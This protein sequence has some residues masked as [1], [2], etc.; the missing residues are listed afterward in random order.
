MIDIII[1]NPIDFYKVD[2]GY[3]FFFSLILDIKISLMHLDV[4]EREERGLVE[5]VDLDPTLPLGSVELPPPLDTSDIHLKW[6]TLLLEQLS[7]ECQ[8]DQNT[9]IEFMNFLQRNQ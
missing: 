3:K 6:V 4:H 8:K 1:L 5:V 7:Q 2:F 9:V